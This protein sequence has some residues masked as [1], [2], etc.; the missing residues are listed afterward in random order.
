[1]ES[2]PP[3]EPRSVSR[4]IAFAEVSCHA[5]AVPLPEKFASDMVTGV[6]PLRTFEITITVSAPSEVRWAANAARLSGLG[7]LACTL[8]S[9]KADRLPS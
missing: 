1:M 9:P 2:E 8:L 5:W 3:L 4:V 6:L 7:T